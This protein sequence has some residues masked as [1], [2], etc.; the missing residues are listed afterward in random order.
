MV[1]TH[2]RLRFGLLNSR[3]WSKRNRR[4]FADEILTPQSIVNSAYALVEFIVQ[5]HDLVK[6]IEHA[7]QFVLTCFPTC[8]VYFC[9]HCNYSIVLMIFLFTQKTKKSMVNI[10]SNEGDQPF[11]K[12]V[13]TP[14]REV[15]LKATKENSLS[16][17]Q[18]ILQLER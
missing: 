18:R 5:A 6:T 14:T 7:A 2:W 4:M 11:I 10:E 8:F 17:K 9:T 16:L 15:T 12:L 1:G 3:L 13:N